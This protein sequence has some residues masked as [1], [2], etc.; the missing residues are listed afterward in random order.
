MVVFRHVLKRWDQLKLAFRVNNWK[1]RTKIFESEASLEIQWRHE[2]LRRDGQFAGLLTSTGLAMKR[3]RDDNRATLVQ[4]GLRLVCHTIARWGG[5]I[6]VVRA[7]QAWRR[8]SFQ[9]L[10]NA[11]MDLKSETLAPCCDDTSIA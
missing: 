3:H 5:A 2:I 6:A 1:L 7:V 4:S 10:V 8:H 9:G 11:A